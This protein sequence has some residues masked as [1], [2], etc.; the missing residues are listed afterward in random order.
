MNTIREFRLLAHPWM[1]AVAVLAAP[2]LL[3]GLL[4][5]VPALDATLQSPE[6]HF[7]V[8][9]LV[10]ATALA[11]ALAVIWAARSLPDARTLFLAMG[12]LAMSCIFFAHALGSMPLTWRQSGGAGTAR[13][14]AVV[15]APVASG[16]AAAG[17]D[18]RY[19]PVAAA[20]P[21]LAATV[22]R[23]APP[24]P[25]DLARLRSVGFS[26]Y[27]SLFVSAFCFALATIR[28][29]ERLAVFV[30]RRWT[31][32]A[33]LIGL[34]VTGYLAVALQAPA[35]LAFLPMNTPELNRTAAAVTWVLLAFAA[36]RFFQAYRLASLPLQGMMALGMVLLMEAQLFMLLGTLWKLRWWQ[37][38]ATMLAGFLLPVVG[39]LRQFRAAGDLGVVVEGL[40]LRQTVRGLRQGDA[41]ALTG[42]AAAVSAKD[43][44]TG[45]HIERVGDLAVAIGRR[46]GLE[47][48]RLEALRLAGRFHDL[49]KIGVPNNL[50]HKP[51]PLTPAEFAVMKQHSPRGWQVAR[52]S[53]A[54]ARIAP[55]IRAHHERMDGTGYP[56]GL[57]G[58]AIPLEARIIAVADVWD[59]LICDRPYRKAMSPDEAAR[60]VCGESGTKLDSRC[61]AALFAELEARAWASQPKT[62]M[63][64]TLLQAA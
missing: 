34:L 7:V 60:I 45:E 19:Q 23:P 44:E 35:W 21:G 24:S 14:P 30:V 63:G 25:T 10:S 29:R 15:P 9:S 16:S 41:G 32:L 18:G 56:D 1:I 4:M 43:S 46:L 38:H 12:F 36:W 58:D 17:D 39:L 22:V 11:L 61:V 62:L 64:Y 27:L 55:F 20:A 31:P 57:H 8:V 49:G 59:A 53:G 52:R 48:D 28:P 47:G 50:L 2:V 13:A 6:W 26:G 5:A 42:L 3:F 33:G 54:L 40:F 51:G 37:Y